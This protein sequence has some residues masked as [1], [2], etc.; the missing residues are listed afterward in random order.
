MAMAIS[1]DAP[2]LIILPLS[3]THLTSL[4][5]QMSHCWHMHWIQDLNQM[6]RGA[7]G[8]EINEELMV[9]QLSKGLLM[10]VYLA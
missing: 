3:F 1:L 7:R 8:T 2:R 6:S 5:Y 9:M 10:P 4:L